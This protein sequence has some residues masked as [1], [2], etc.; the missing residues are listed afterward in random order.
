MEVSIEQIDDDFSRKNNSEWD[1]FNHLAL[2]SEIESQ[3][4]IVF[5]MEEVNQINSYK[6]LCE[7][8]LKKNETPE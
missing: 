3:M 5:S 4:G 6:D 1:S 2:I 8:V 7:I